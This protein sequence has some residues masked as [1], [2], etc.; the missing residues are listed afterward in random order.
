M[1]FHN[2]HG[3]PLILNISKLPRLNTDRKFSRNLPPFCNPNWGGGRRLRPL[4]WANPNYLHG[5][6]PWGVRTADLERHQ[7]SF[8]V[9]A[10]DKQK[11]NIH[12]AFSFLLAANFVCCWTDSVSVNSCLQLL[13][14]SL[15]TA[16][17]LAESGNNSLCVHHHKQSLILN[18]LIGAAFW[19]L[20]PSALP[21]QHDVWTPSP[22]ALTP[23]PKIQMMEC[24]GLIQQTN[25]I[26]G[27][28]R[29][30]SR[31]TARR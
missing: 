1:H 23:E 15:M 2:S 11:S 5:E 30:I 20:G 6:I 27:N 3:K 4:H 31:V 22:A 18:I 26:C 14:T 29:R 25:T 17:R 24:C 21:R 9:T 13:K 28:V 8:G 10:P 16:M 7:H 19:N 12:S